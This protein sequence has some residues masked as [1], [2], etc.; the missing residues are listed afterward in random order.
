[1]HALAVSHDL[2]GARPYLQHRWTVSL[3]Y[4]PCDEELLHCRVLAIVFS[5]RSGVSAG[6]SVFVSKCILIMNGIA[7]NQM[8]KEC[9]I[10]TVNGESETNT[11]P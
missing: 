6:P 11:L 5:E 8:H 3:A 2:A 7:I 4:S 9:K 1:M 10:T